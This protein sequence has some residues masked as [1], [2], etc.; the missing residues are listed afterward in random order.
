MRVLLNS[1]QRTCRQSADLSSPKKEM[2][3]IQILTFLTTALAAFSVFTFLNDRW[4]LRRE[5]QNFRRAFARL[6]KANR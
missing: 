5:R 2:I 1:I 4:A 3:M 6:Q